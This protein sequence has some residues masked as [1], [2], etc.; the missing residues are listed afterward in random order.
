MGASLTNLVLGNQ[1]SFTALTAADILTHLNITDQSQYAYVQTLLNA[2]VVYVERRL[3][4]DLRPTYWT[5]YL[6]QFPVWASFNWL[7]R[8][9]NYINVYPNVSEYAIGRLTQRWQEIPLLRGPVQGIT[10]VGYF[11]T[12]NT[13]NVMESDQ[14]TYVAGSFFPACIEPTIYWPISYPRPDAVQIEYV[15]GFSDSGASGSG[16]NAPDNVPASIL[17]ALKLLCGQWYMERTNGSFGPNTVMG[18]TGCAIDALL[19][20]FQVQAIG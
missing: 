11:D 3:Q 6:D 14:Y 17:H 18:A 13:W 15:T 16:Y 20:Q 5:L 8:W 9:G 1:S 7:D 10:Q 4:L 2:A 19:D 12:T